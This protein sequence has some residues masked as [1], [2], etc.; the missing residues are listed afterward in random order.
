MFVVFHNKADLLNI[1]HFQDENTW[2]L[3]KNQEWEGWDE[4]LTEKKLSGAH[5]QILGQ[6]YKS[7]WLATMKFMEKISS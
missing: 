5:K 1:L 4:N 6:I 7:D 2:K 3:I